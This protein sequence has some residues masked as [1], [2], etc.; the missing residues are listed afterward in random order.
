M[1][2]TER[3]FRYMQRVE[4]DK[5]AA[6]DESTLVHT[7][8][9][10]GLDTVGYGHKLNVL[11]KSINTVYGFDLDTLTRE[12]CD[13]ILSMDI[14]QVASNLAGRVPAWKKRSQRQQE[15]LVDMQ[16]NVGNVERTFPKFYQAVLKNDI[17]GQRKEY[18]RFYTDKMGI[19]RELKRRNRFF[20]SRYLSPEAL[21]EWG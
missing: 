7:S 10:G 9:E 18:K 15:M 6:G 16:F 17:E 13:Y 12:Q 4:N 1:Q 20:Y 19:K 5:L 8:P 14:E 2:Q 21:R 11:E 3:F